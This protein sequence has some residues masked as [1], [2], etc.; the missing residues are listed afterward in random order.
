MS[1]HGHFESQKQ[2]KQPK[3]KMNKGLKITLIVLA[4]LIVLIAAIAIA[5]WSY[6]N[7][8]A[9][10][11]NIVT[12]PSIEY[13]QALETEATEL[14]EAVETTAETTEETT[15][16]TTVPPMTADDIVNVLVVGQASRA[17][18]ESHMADSTI[19]VSLNTYTGTV[20]L[21]SVLRD[22]FVQLPAYT[23]TNN[24]NHTAGAA[25]FTTAYNLGYTFGGV[26][27]AMAYTNLTL[28]N[29]FGVEV[30]YNI[31]IDF[32]SFTKV[33]DYLDGIDVEL[34][35]AEAD[36]LNKDDLYVLYDV[37]AGLQHLDGMA[38]LSYARMRKAE[39]DND[40]D[41]NRT[42]RQRIVIEKLLEKV[43]YLSLSEL[44]GVAET[45][46]PLITTTMTATDIASLLIKVAPII[47]NLT[48]EGDTIPVK[49]TYWGDY[50]DIYG[51]GMQHSILRF[52]AGQNKKLIRAV[53]EAEIS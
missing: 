18:E 42:A 3:K 38:A 16:E 46:L 40:S 25:K 32:E 33:I 43:R 53:T 49:D 2:P 45:L 37:E 17:G 10:Q 21:Y 11:M 22:T 14:T 12:L 48:I 47:S 34:T 6:F 8:M 13:T 26:E 5:A 19:L 1:Y 39:G 15:E 28:Y 41:I 24:K 36:Y 9:N 7:K 4:V 31:E 20:T 50:L 23:D 44:Q 27:D 30:D 51:D 35:Q 29:N 52:D